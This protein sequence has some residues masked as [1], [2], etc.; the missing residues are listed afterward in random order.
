MPRC[1]SFNAHT[2]PPCSLQTRRRVQ[3]LSWLRHLVLV[4][5][6]N[7][8]DAA[9][10]NL[11]GHCIR[12]Y[13]PNWP[14]D[15]VQHPPMENQLGHLHGRRQSET[16]MEPAYSFQGAS[17]SKIKCFSWIGD[18]KRFSVPYSQ[19]TLH[20][21]SKDPRNTASGDQNSTVIFPHPH[22]LVMID[23]DRLWTPLPNNGTE[24]EKMA[25][26]EVEANADTTG[27]DDNG[28]DTDSEGRASDCPGV[29]TILRFVP[30]NPSV[31]EGMYNALAEC[32]ALNPDLQDELSN[33]DLDDLAEED[34]EEDE[35]PG[36][37][38]GCSS[39]CFLCYAIERG[40]VQ[41]LFDSIPL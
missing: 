37:V 31:L 28:E 9:S 16:F 8:V 3:V 33:S 41:A 29:T 34:G 26:D 14:S 39:R 19:I 23:G 7:K 1:S 22:L 24:E 13:R 32:Q 2:T 35:H 5:A 20:A 17:R 25:V 4:G 18:T 21:I 36:N 6:A 11:A 40:T 30:A 15:S 12:R 38:L 27:E 10:K